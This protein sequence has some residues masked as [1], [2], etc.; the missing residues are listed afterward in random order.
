MSDPTRNQDAIEI[1]NSKGFLRIADAIRR[2]TV[3]AQW[4]RSQFDDRTY[5]VRYGLGQEL[6]RHARYEKEF[7]A[8]L[9]EFLFEYNAETARE[10][11]KA[12]RE[13]TKYNNGKARPLTAQDR[14]E[15]HLR[16]MTDEADL[17][18][19]AALVKDHGSEVVGSL[20]VACGYSLKEDA[21]NVQKQTE[22]P[23]SVD[24]EE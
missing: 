9:S 14:K 8:A 13:I 10:D 5:E 20:L 17:K 23:S 2:A 11:E 24:A 16:W 21:S 18:E 19:V 15:R 3:F 22:E 4:Q 12:A 6:M 7:L 1:F